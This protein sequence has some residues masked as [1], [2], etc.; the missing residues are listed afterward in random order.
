VTYWDNENKKDLTH[1]VGIITRITTN[2][3]FYSSVVV[4]HYEIKANEK[5]LFLQV[6]NTL[7]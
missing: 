7:S 1:G 4:V 3:E 5:L 2:L 6:L